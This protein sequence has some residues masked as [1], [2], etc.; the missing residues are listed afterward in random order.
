MH[1]HHPTI[2]QKFLKVPDNQSTEIIACKYILH[3]TY[4]SI[5]NELLDT[6]KLANYESIEA[7][8]GEYRLPPISWFKSLPFSIIMFFN[9]AKAVQDFSYILQSLGYGDIFVEIHGLVP[10][11]QR[12]FNLNEFKRQKQIKLLLCTDACA[13]GLDIPFVKFVVQSEFASNV[14]QHLHR[15]GRASRGGTHGNAIN[16][17]RSADEALVSSIRGQNNPTN[18]SQEEEYDSSISNPSCLKTSSI[19]N[20][21]SRRRSFRKKMKKAQS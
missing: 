17:Y 19:E 5:E 4:L 9:T 20:S 10:K 8:S 21:F 12:E 16:F 6:S 2:N 13:R 18:N 14:V 7:S 11:M 15:V 3:C 1:Q